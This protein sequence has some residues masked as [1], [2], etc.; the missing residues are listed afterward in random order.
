MDELYILS[1]TWGSLQRPSHKSQLRC[2]DDTGVS[3][4][5]ML[6]PLRR[7]HVMLEDCSEVAVIEETD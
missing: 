5:V 3:V 2:Y 1:L 6:R 4:E 7:L